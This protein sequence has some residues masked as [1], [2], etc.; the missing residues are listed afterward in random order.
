MTLRKKKLLK[1]L[2]YAMEIIHLYESEIDLRIKLSTIP[3]GFCQGSVFEHAIRDIK[4][5][6]G[7]K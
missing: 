5:E 6:A 7:I 1:G 4:R 2:E 3:K